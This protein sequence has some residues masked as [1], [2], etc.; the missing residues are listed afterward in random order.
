METPR[1]ASESTTTSSASSREKKALLL[2][3]PFFNKERLSALS[4][5]VSDNPTEASSQIRQYK[6]LLFSLQS[7][8][9]LEGKEIIPNAQEIDLR[10]MQM[11][12]LYRFFSQLEHIAESAR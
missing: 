11:D 7:M 12:T 1:P 9:Y 6:D 3:D 5:L 2:S 8:L 4:S 10:Y